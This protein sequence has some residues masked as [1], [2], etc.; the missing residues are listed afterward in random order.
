MIVPSAPASLGVFEAT[1]VLIL[2]GYPVDHAA[3][4]TYALC[5]HALNVVPLVAAGAIAMLTL[6]HRQKAPMDRSM[7]VPVATQLGAVEIVVT[8]L[9][10]NPDKDAQAV[11]KQRR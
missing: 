3:A 5:L 4:V 9:T 11:P 10:A 8:N 6:A 1:T 7:G 2:R